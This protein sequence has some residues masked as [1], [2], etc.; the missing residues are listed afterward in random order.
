MLRSDQPRRPGWVKATA[1]AAVCL[2]A[3][4]GVGKWALG[5]KQGGEAAWRD[6]DELRQMYLVPSSYNF[7]ETNKSYENQLIALVHDRLLHYDPVQNQL[8]PGLAR[9]Y[10]SSADGL[11]WTFRLRDAQTPD[12]VKLAADDV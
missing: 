5:R 4:L 7:V 11:T 1:L 10:E 6:V 2:L 9:T 8:V 12:G 3:G